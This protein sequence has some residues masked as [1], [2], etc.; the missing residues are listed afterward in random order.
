MRVL[1]FRSAL[2][3]VREECCCLL[4]CVIATRG[5]ERLSVLFIYDLFNDAVSSSKYMA[6]KS[7]MI[8]KRNEVPWPIL[9]YHRDIL[10]ARLR[11]FSQKSN[12]REGN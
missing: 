9:R 5:I 3:Q 4:F 11:K 2:E 8:L 10:L 12:P 1:L 6:S 7:G